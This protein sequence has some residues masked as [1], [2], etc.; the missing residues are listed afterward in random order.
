MTSSVGDL[1]RYVR[2]LC[3]GTLLKPGTQRA[4]M[5][6]QVPAGTQVAYGEGVISNDG[7]CGHSGTVPGFNTDM[8]HVE[9]LG[10]SLVVSVNRLD[11]DNAPHTGAF[12]AAVSD[13]PTA[14]FGK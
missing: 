1:L 7:F 2:V 5:A 8:Y 12:R 13:A 11:R 4:R 10:A 6:G 9:H 3:T 14:Q